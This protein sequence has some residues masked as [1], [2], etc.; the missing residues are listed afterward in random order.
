M[1]YHS[2]HHAT[3]IGLDKCSTFGLPSPIAAR[4]SFRHI[5]SDSTSVAKF[6]THVFDYLIENKVFHSF[7]E[8]LLDLD[9]TARPY[10]TTD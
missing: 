8:F 5:Q 9:S 2:D 10:I 1:L 6:V 7:S 4:T 3:F